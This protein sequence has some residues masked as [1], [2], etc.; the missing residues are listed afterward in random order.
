[1][2]WQ[3]HI[4]FLWSNESTEWAGLEIICSFPTWGQLD[5]G[6]LAAKECPDLPG[7]ESQREGTLHFHAKELSGRV[8]RAIQRTHACTGAAPKICQ[9]QWENHGNH[10][11]GATNKAV[12]WVKSYLSLSLFLPTST[13]WRSNSQS[14]EKFQSQTTTLNHNFQGS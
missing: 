8:Y 1:M 6:G 9:W 11:Q 3:E 2:S 5:K 14:I 10:S 4:N 12:N 7:V 13:P